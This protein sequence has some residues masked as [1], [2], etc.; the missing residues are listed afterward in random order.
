MK[1]LRIVFMGSPDFAVP[2]LEKLSQSSHQ[3]VAVLSNP[4]KRRGRRK[5]PEPTA[6]KKRAL[7][8]QLPV[9]D[10]VD[11]QSASFQKQLEELK[12]DLFVVVAFRILP[13][14]LL[15][16]PSIGSVNL[17]AS[18][19]PRYRGAAPIHW[20]VINGETE[21]GCTVF[22]LDSKVD[23]G[24]I[25]STVRTPIG[26]C[27]TTGELYNRLKEKGAAL[28]AET[29]DQIASGRVNPVKQ[30]HSLATPAPK[31]FR[32]NTRIDFNRTAREVHNFVRGLNPFPGAWCLYDD[33]KMNIHQTLPAEDL[34]AEPG[35]LIVVNNRLYAG[36]G[37][38]AVELEELQLPGRKKIGGT[39]F[40]NSY[41]TS[42]R[43]F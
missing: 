42:Y 39:D 18:L 4:D 30:D 14:S 26:P 16:T 2:S 41:D 21:T 6:V 36:C 13:D 11:L 37:E 23:T 3:I 35:E 1:S 27:E 12:A 5:A 29:V 31:L 24:D 40:A 8:L 33:L 20:A 34:S 17:H 9:I 32:E 10:A 15:N 38:G 19:L 43:L 7:E 22:F 28:L 25:I